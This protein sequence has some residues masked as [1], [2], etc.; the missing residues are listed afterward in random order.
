MPLM[1]YYMI[2]GVP[3][4]AST[5]DIQDAHKREERIWKKRAATSSDA[6]VKDEA[7]RRLTLLKEAL[8]TLSNAQRRFTYGRQLEVSQNAPSSSP[9]P[10]EVSPHNLIEQAKDYLAEA[11]YFAAAR[12]AREATIKLSD[13]AESW[14]ILSRAKAGLRE[15][16][17]A[18]YEAKRAIELYPANSKYYFN[19]GMIYEELGLW[20]EALV[21]YEQA[22]QRE[23]SESLYQLATGG[24]YIQTNQPTEAVSI[25]KHVYSTLPDDETVCYYYAQALITQAEAVP[26]DK[27]EEGYAITNA[28]E[29]LQMRNCL[30][31]A[32]AIKHLDQETKKTIRDME[33]HLNL[34]ESRTFHIPLG[35]WTIAEISSGDGG[36]YPIVVM[37]LAM[38]ALFGAPLIVLMWGFSSLTS[39]SVLGGLFLILCGVGLGYIWYRNVWVP[40]WKVNA[41]LRNHRVRYLS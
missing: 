27:S 8:D 40:K 18:V 32:S 33:A 6:N 35:A 19:L 1:N 5:E 15:L 2:L 31:R 14:F 38:A 13:L 21:M 34:M 36:C 28:E 9:V 37:I 29:I 39:G 16:N 11:N 41:R 23:P 3:P 4:N 20:K 30:N 22:S 26:R 10:N 12:V 7:L 17:D 25:I 24:V